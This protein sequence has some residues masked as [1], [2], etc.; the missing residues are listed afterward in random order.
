MNHFQM[1]PTATIIW[2]EKEL[3]ILHTISETLNYVEEIKKYDF[4]NEDHLS[5]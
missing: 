1:Q 3:L 4:G 5:L 2:Y